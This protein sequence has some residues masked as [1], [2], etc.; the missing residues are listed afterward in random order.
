[1]RSTQ[2]ESVNLAILILAVLFLTGTAGLALGV[3]SLQ[4]WASRMTQFPWL[5]DAI[6]LLRRKGHPR[7]LVAI[8]A[9]TAVIWSVTILLTYL[10]FSEVSDVFS[11]F[12]AIILS[13][14]L[15][16]AIAVPSTPAGL[17]TVEAGAVGYLHYVL[18]VAP[19]QAL[20]AALTFHAIIAFPQVIAA[21]AIIVWNSDLITW[22]RARL[23]GKVTYN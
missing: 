18:S 10:I 19:D 5:F 15:A 2:I 11:V 13:V 6:V 9:S 23:I 17:G 12:D 4:N 21:M 16:A 22:L 20:A 7:I 3:Y 8:V 14:V 1:V